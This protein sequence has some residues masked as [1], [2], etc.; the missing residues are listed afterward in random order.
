M[1][2]TAPVLLETQEYIWSKV[3]EGLRNG[4]LEKIY[5]IVHNTR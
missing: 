2:I 4:E 3:S 1:I 5:I